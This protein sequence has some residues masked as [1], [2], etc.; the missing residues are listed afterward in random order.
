[1][2]WA[3]LALLLS[4]W[5]APVLA[6]A[7]LPFALG[8]AFSLIDHEGLLRSEADPDG[9]PQLLFFGY[10]AC[11]Q[12]CSVA[13]PMM[14]EAARALEA[15]GIA[16]TPVM[17][18][19]DPERDTPEVMAERLRALHPGFVGLTGSRE[20]LA[21]AYAAFRVE[22]EVVYVDPFAGDVFAHGSFV[23][24]LDAEGNFRTLFPPIL[25]PERAVEIVRA[26]VTRPAGG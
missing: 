5:C 17:I 20:A 14:A 26:H 23:Y 7:P 25:A 4:V 11:E 24:L 19:V 18:T 6:Q 8:G 3:L 13:L 9:Q 2:R 1:M 15:D 12:I 16:V 22:H 21:A 10:A